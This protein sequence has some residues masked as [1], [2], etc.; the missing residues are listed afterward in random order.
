MAPP[1]PALEQ[2]RLMRPARTTMLAP[3]ELRDDA[4]TEEDSTPPADM[5]CK[6]A[7]STAATETTT[8]YSAVGT[9]TS[10]RASSGML[11]G[12]AFS[13]L[14]NFLVQIGIVRYLTKSEY[15]AFAWALAAV[16][17]VQAVVPLGLDRAS[18]R[19]LTLY[20]ERRDYNRLFGLMVIELIVI[21]GMGVLVVGG[22]LVLSGTLEEIAPSSSA[23]VILLVLI[24]LAPIQAL[25]VILVEMFAVFASPWSVFLRRYVMEPA[26]RL[27]VVA[28][29]IM[30]DQ[31]AMFLTVGFVLVGAVG[32]TLYLIL[33]LRL[34][35]R[36]G[37]AQHFSMRGIVLPWSEVAR[38]CGPVMLMSLVAVAT[39]ELAA[40]ILG[41]D[42]G[43]TEVAELRAVL[44]FAV[45]NLGVFFTFTTLFTPAAARLVARGEHQSVRDLYWQSAMWVAVLTFPV[46]AATTA[47]ARPFTVF[48]LGD[49]YAS[50][51]VILMI[52]S[53][54]YYLNA[55]FG[56]NGLIVQLLGRSKWV[57]VTSGLTLLVMVVATFVLVPEYLAV[58]AAFSVLITLVVH[59]LLKQLG[60]G[61]GAGI[62]IVH[63]AHSVVILQVGLAV[64]LM[65]GFEYWFEPGLGIGLLIVVVM[66]LLLLRRTRAHLRLS[67][68]FPEATRIPG[69]RWL[70]SAPLD[71]APK[72]AD[73]TP[74]SIEY[75]GPAAL[76]QWRLIDWRFLI[77]AHFE[78]AGYVGPVTAEEVQVLRESGAQVTT[79][80]A[81]GS[82]VDV[83]ITTEAQEDRVAADAAALRAGGWHVMRLGTCRQRPWARLG[84]GSVGHWKKVLE[85]QGYD[86]VSAYWHAPNDQRCSYIV[87]I[88]DTI[89][90]DA[91]LS[92][93]HGVRFGQLKSVLTRNLNRAGLIQLIARDISVV[94]RL[95]E[96]DGV[97]PPVETPVSTMPVRDLLRH[98]HTR[99]S[100]LLVTPWF[101]ASRHVVGLFYDP[102]DAQLISVAKFPR[103]E[104]DTSGINVE[105]TALTRIAAD[106]P[107]LD[108]YLPT[109]CGIDLGSRPHLI[110]TA[111]VGA[112]ANPEYVREY[113]HQVLNAGLDLV[114]RLATPRQRVRRLAARRP[115]ARIHDGAWFSRLIE[116]PLQR[117]ATEVPVG[118]EGPDLVNR[119]LDLLAP[120]RTARLPPVYEHGDLSHPNL[121]MTTAERMSALDWERFEL[122]GL[123]G[124]DLI[125]LMQYIGECK[126]NAI[127]RRSQLAAF[128]HA[129]VGPDAWAR[130]ALTRY[131]AQV[132]INPNLLP[133]LVLSTWART[134]T[135]LLERLAPARSDE[136]AGR[137][138]DPARL[139]ESFRLDRD[140]AI[141]RHAVHRFDS[142]L[143]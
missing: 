19:F 89:A 54:G 34:F 47:L 21:V 124:H 99:P 120:L 130:P 72:S 113:P 88:S 12:Y 22:A 53:V 134:S 39:T 122:D 26:L 102:H 45:L 1:P 139:A 92:R 4:A 79:S 65:Y 115:T 48:A 14:I 127:Q 59:N 111:L 33:L 44:P 32:L 8:R 37:L 51:A 83:V 133:R 107:G 73:P 2:T 140:Y 9:Q 86:C 24:A 62:G 126:I 75:T 141:W 11:V 142:I 52:L 70:L 119:T 85:R 49:R 36:N 82:D 135:G 84:R 15:G 136:P 16:L 40:V 30:F 55:A 101:E 18:A 125:F 93:Y 123:P 58:G 110:E 138:A 87:D 116:Q 20:D 132:G 69:L 103:R 29:L 118:P 10:I 131:A 104:W 61:F 41:R 17:L 98:R 42:G 105:A 23:V 43:S 57:L 117:F 137:M 96:V 80:L 28:L 6:E 114:G 7:R 66:W 90:V 68:V 91:M 71:T 38:F 108:G 31:Q 74:P 56:F 76:A 128:D 109:V 46:L 5:A 94:G 27:L 100:V 35:R 64:V 77:P 121:I 63:R 60:L 106:I 25:D 95:S 3:G 81:T 50:S 112:A 129:F 78:R 97:A 67:D 143:R 13:Q